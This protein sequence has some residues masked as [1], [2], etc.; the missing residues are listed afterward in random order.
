VSKVIVITGAGDGLGRTLARSFAGDGHSVVLVGRTAAKVE[1]VAAELGGQAM[2]LACDVS[3]PD[4]VR[5]TFA[6]IAE[7]HPK[8][9]VLI[10][11][12]AIFTPAVIAE[13]SDDHILSTIGINLT[14]AMFCARAAIGMMQA[15]GHIIN[16]TS[17]SVELP[18]AHLVAY[19]ASKAG[20]ERFSLGL[21]RELE[22]AGIR[23][24]IVRAGQMYDE[25][26]T[27]PWPPEVAIRFLQA[28]I[29]R[30]IDVRTRP[31][32][33]YNSLL[34]V[35][36]T[37]VDLPPDVHVSNVQVQARTAT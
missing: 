20:L 6:K 25:T 26:K 24:T 22:G 19:Q 31:I 34:G 35:F 36:R 8:I 10:N 4:Q 37:L 17:E 11:S 2:A 27:S 7:R 13:A 9:D 30:G 18:F 23:V 14:G 16:V 21:A 3:N 1:A 28:N 29:E 15:G 32:T 12:A 33:H 5:A